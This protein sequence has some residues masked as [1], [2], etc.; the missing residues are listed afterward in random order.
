MVADSETQDHPGHRLG[1][2]ASGPG[3]VASWKL[4]FLAL[5]ID[6]LPSVLLANL[7]AALWGLTSAESAF[8]P[9]GVFFV[10]VTVFTALT[11]G[12]FGQL[13]TRLTVARLDGSR[14]SLGRAALRTVLI[15]LV[16]PAVVFNQ[17][18][19]GLHDLAA[20]TVLLRR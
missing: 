4:R 2:P 9:L 16:I 11:G 17:D 5:L 13:A 19:R 12:S 10:E 7:L 20:G 14:V 15:C 6:W 8:L 1:L 3:S 18:N